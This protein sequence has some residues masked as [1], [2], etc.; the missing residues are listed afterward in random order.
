L[1][2]ELRI[3]NGTTTDDHGVH[4]VGWMNHAGHDWFLIKDSGRSARRG[5]F[6]GYY[7][8]RDDYIKLK[9]LSFMVH[10]DAVVD[11]LKKIH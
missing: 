11:V 5:R 3:Y 8:V 7:F 2:R 4:V 1:S 9:V 10:R 6:K